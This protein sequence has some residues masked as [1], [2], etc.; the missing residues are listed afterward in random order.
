MKIYRFLS[1]DG[2]IGHAWQSPDQPLRELTL[3]GPHLQD[4]F[5]K[6]DRPAVVARLLAPVIPQAILCIGLNYRKH[7]EETGA[8]I[9][10][11]PVLFLKNPAALQDPDAPIQLP[12]HLISHKV[13]YEAELAVVIG[14]RCKN[15]RREDALS[16]VLGYTAA[17]DVSARDWQ[18]EGGTQWCRGKGFDT[19]C[20]LGP[21]LVTPES[22][23]DPNAL[24][25]R[26]LLNGQ[27]VQDS[28]TSDMI[29]SVAEIVEFLS[30]STTLLPGTVILTGT[31]SGV[32]MAA[33]PPRFLTP[34][35]SVTVEIEGIG[36]LTNPVEAE[37]VPVGPWGANPLAPRTATA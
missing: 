7:A 34:G 18:K 21:A 20:P 10:S 8:A 19:F 3:H 14:T 31:P 22:L 26:T 2:H 24:R 15:V 1:P 11:H 30:A 6:T 28:H 23:P 25:I 27:C 17:N 4:G 13:D 35:D 12:R 16:H 5:S 9:P 32:G 37:P 29:F 33:K 36:A